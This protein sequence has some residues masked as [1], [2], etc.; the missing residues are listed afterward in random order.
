MTAKVA[1]ITWT[2]NWINLWL[3]DFRSH[4][5]SLT[6]R[7]LR[8]SCSGQPAAQRPSTWQINRTSES[9]I[10]RTHH[11][12]LRALSH[13]TPLWRQFHSAQLSHTRLFVK[14][15]GGRQKTLC[16]LGWDNVFLSLSW[17]SPWCS[18][19]LRQGSICWAVFCGVADGPLPRSPNS[20]LYMLSPLLCGRPN[21][22]SR[23]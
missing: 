10:P 14:G 16:I 19:S 4:V 15:T 1:G 23:M 8:V 3:L 20:G 5:C 7:V 6:S 11:G 9:R 12:Q 22:S 2:Q 13:T 21:C 18:R 17:F